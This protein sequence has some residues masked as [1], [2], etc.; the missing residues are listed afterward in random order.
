MGA[1]LA[2][3]IGCKETGD[4]AIKT[5]SGEHVCKSD[6]LAVPT[7][8]KGLSFGMT[9]EQ[10]K[11]ALGGARLRPRRAHR[12]TPFMSRDSKI[13]LK[14]RRRFLREATRIQ[15]GMIVAVKTTLGTESASCTLSFAVD[16]KLSSIECKM[17]ARSKKKYKRLFDAIR[18]RLEK[19]H[20]AAIISGPLYRWADN[21]ALLL[22]LGQKYKKGTITLTNLSVAHSKLLAKLTDEAERIQREKLT[23]YTNARSAAAKKRADKADERSKAWDRD[24]SATPE[25]NK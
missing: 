24:L 18:I 9:L 5:S 15:P 19:R 4:R 13:P 16:S 6:C 25:S 12:I 11:E 7:G 2:T 21:K 23:A 1:A 17:S 20:G 8:I 10:A 14:V 3:L 22:L